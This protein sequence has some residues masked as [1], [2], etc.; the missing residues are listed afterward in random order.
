MNAAETLAVRLRAGE[1]RALAQALSYAESTSAAHVGF[2]QMLTDALGPARDEAL[3]IGVTGVPGA[4]K[5]T[6]IDRLGTHWTGRG[7]RVAVLAVDPSSVRSGGSILGDKLRMP[8]LSLDPNAFIRP[9]A[10]RGVAGGVAAHL[11]DCMRLCEQ[12]GYDIVLTE[13]VGVGQ[14]EV[15]AA[16]LC[17]VLALVILPG[18]GDEVQALKRGITEVADMIVVNK[19]DGEQVQAARRAAQQYELGV[20]IVQGQATGVASRVRVCSALDGFGIDELA[21]EL[22]DDARRQAE[23]EIRGGKRQALFRRSLERLS[24]NAFWR[25]MEAWSGLAEVL[26][27]VGSSELT[28]R[29]ALA[30]VPR[31]LLGSG[32]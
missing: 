21:V 19:A 7:W 10:S 8:R 17:D 27:A 12:A 29:Q 1:R 18:A 22:L 9:I 23:P 16:E 6:L 15:E 31:R 25:Q 30:R 14:G 11:D 24:V 26:V 3:R 32:A 28:L 20:R 13:T 2:M 4:G 5:S